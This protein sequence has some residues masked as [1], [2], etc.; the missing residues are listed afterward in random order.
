MKFVDKLLIENGMYK[1][2]QT[3]K[4]YCITKDKTLI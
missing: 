2:K 3:C 4:K 1:Y